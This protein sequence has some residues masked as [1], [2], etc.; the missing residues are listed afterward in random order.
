MSVPTT[1]ANLNSNTQLKKNP[2]EPS[3]HFFEDIFRVTI[4]QRMT[5]CLLFGNTVKRALMHNYSVVKR[6]HNAKTIMDHAAIIAWTD[7]Q[8]HGR[9]QQMS[10]SLHFLLL[11]LHS[12]SSLHCVG[13]TLNS[14]YNPQLDMGLT[15]LSSNSKRFLEPLNREGGLAC[16]W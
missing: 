3:G 10:P 15:V 9:A 8:T 12:I 4:A 1:I 6:S 16:I 5:H 14:L 11:A 13:S 7:G 2:P